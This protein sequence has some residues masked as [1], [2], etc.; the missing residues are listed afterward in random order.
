[1]E[2]EI[3]KWIKEKEEDMV[4]GRNNISPKY[5][6]NQELLFWNLI[7]ELKELI[8]NKGISLTPRE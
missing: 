1:M 4:K 5:T 2:K 3:K 7:N 8:K 6:I